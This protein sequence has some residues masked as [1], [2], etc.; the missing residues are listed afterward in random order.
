LPVVPDRREASANNPL[1]FLEDSEDNSDK[2]S[3][4]IDGMLD[5]N[6]GDDDDSRQIAGMDIA[7][8]NDGNNIDAAYNADDGEEDNASQAND[9]V[10][11][12]SWKQQGC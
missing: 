12:G 6:G 7:R 3:A 11:S 9:N 8:N 1:L 5:D 4:H 2:Q 10:N